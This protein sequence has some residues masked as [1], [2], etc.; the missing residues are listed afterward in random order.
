M[1][2][3]KGLPD[4][5]EL[6]MCK[7]KRITP[8]A[9]WCDLDEYDAEGMIHVSQAAGKWVHDIRDFVKPGR[10]YVAKVMKLDPEKK[11]VS[12]SLKSVSRRDQKGKAN[13]YRR[14]QR[15]EKVLE[16]AAKEMGKTMKQAYAEVGYLLQEKFG[17]L[18]TAFEE[19]KKD[20][21]ELEEAGVP[22]KWIDALATFIDKMFKDKEVVLKA[23]LDLK[24]YEGD[25]VARVKKL[26]SEIEKSGMSVRYISAPRYT[27][28][29]KTKKPK[30]DV[31]RMRE[32]LDALAEKSKGM[33]VEFGYEM[34]K[35]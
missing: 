16:Q 7:V 24:S 33:K 14:E 21:K 27:A 15:A 30:T 9:A 10:T 32:A 5:N 11:I 8:Y 13:A 28:E 17:E 29:L 6:V 23:K 4:K 3:R 22:K 25:G 20:R 1:M 2:K 26:L 12:L 34:V 18:S 19:G 31:K 35:Q